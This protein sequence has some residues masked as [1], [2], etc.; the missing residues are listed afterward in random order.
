MRKK[1]HIRQTK[2]PAHHDTV[3]AQLISSG[4]IRKVTCEIKGFGLI[5]D[6]YDGLHDMLN[7]MSCHRGLDIAL[8]KWTSAD[9]ASVV[10]GCPILPKFH[11]VHLAL[12][13]NRLGSKHIALVKNALA[14]KM[15][16]DT[17]QQL[18]PSDD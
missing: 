15:S 11:L 10:N 12:I 14:A 16:I 3:R 8:G 17:A 6:P 7:L 4:I 9:K 1:E 18:C 2:S 13:K 5:R